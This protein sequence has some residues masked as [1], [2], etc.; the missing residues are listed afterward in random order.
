MSLTYEEM[1]AV[2]SAKTGASKAP[3]D[4]TVNKYI[5]LD[6][7]GFERAIPIYNEVPKFRLSATEKIIYQM[8]IDA[9]AEDA[10]AFLALTPIVLLS[11]NSAKGK[12]D[13]GKLQAA[14][15]RMQLAKDQ[16]KAAAKV[17]KEDDQPPF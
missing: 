6:F 11:V 2:A 15:A 9:S 17:Q 5:N 7:G 1:L 13:T 12:T 16:V 8:L 10:Q 3:V 4:N 14:Q